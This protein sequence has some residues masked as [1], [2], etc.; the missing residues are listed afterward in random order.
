MQKNYTPYTLSYK[1]V[2]TT[3]YIGGHID[4]L[5]DYAGKLHLENWSLYDNCRGEIIMQS[6]NGI[7]DVANDVDDYEEK[8]IKDYLIKSYDAAT[9]G[10]DPIA[11]FFKGLDPDF[12]VAVGDKK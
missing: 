7:V 11:A 8:C 6:I 12:F 2:Y 4:E 5:L 3:R 10:M 9:K 1:K